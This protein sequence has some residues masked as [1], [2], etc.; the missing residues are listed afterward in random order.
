MLLVMM[1]MQSV[2]WADGMPVDPNAGSGGAGQGSG[3]WPPAGTEPKGA[4]I[5]GLFAGTWYAFVD[6]T[7]FTLIIR[8][9]GQTLKIAHTAIFDYGRRIDS[10]VGG[11]SMVG[12]VSGSLAYVEWKSG[13]S[14]ENGRATLEYGPGRPVTLHW[15]I[16]D[17]PKKSDDTSAKATSSEVAYFLPASAFMIRK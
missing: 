13:L 7:A 4:F 11:V 1:L 16:V 2:G 15:K 9:E 10:S 3:G 8:Q 17:T 5:D 14:P 6:N 12:T